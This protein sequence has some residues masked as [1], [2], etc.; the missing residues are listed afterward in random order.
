M[1]FLTARN[2]LADLIKGL[3]LD[4]DDYLAKPFAFAKLVTRIRTL[5]RC[6]PSHGVD[7]R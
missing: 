6:A 3:E 2:D 1:L 5:L 4:A 7:S